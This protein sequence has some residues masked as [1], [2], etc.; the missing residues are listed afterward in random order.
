[1]ENIRTDYITGLSL[2]KVLSIV[3]SDNKIDHNVIRGIKFRANLTLEKIV[4]RIE[5]CSLKEIAEIS[6]KISRSFRSKIQGDNLDEVDRL[7]CEI[8][9]LLN[10][11]HVTSN[12]LRD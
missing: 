6:S 9:I 4:P 7:T 5:S 8:F 3:L 1:M 11:K 12:G 10:L 2:L